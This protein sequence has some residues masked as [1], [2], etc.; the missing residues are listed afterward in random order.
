MSKRPP[1][2]GDG[3]GALLYLQRLPAIKSFGTDM[4]S[5]DSTEAFTLMP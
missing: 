4:V 1:S 3:E 5:H 2:P